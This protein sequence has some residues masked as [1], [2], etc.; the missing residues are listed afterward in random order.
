MIFSICLSIPGQAAVPDSLS[1]QGYLAD[2]SGSPVNGVSTITFSIYN[3]PIEGIPLWTDMQTVPVD[4]GLFSVLLGNPLNPF[5]PGTFDG[6]L[7]IGITVSGDAE[8]VPRRQLTKV[9]YAF[10]AD[11]ASTVQGL[12][13]EALQG[14]TGPPGPPGPPGADGAQGLTGPEGPQGLTGPE[15]PQGLTGPPGADGAQGLPGPE[16][17]QGL[18]GPPGADGAQ[19]LP[20]PEGPQG[21]TGPEGPQGPAG[22][23][24]P[25]GQGIEACPCWMLFQLVNATEVDLNG[26]LVTRGTGTLWRTAAPTPAF[27]V[28]LQP[29]FPEA[30]LGPQGFSDTINFGESLQCVQDIVTAFAPCIFDS[31]LSSAALVKSSAEDFDGDEILDGNDNCATI[32]NADQRDTNNDGIGNACDPDLNNDCIVNLL[33]LAMFRTVFLTDDADADLNGDGAVNLL[34]LAIARTFFPSEPGPSA[35]GCTAAY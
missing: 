24:G 6:P 5:P 23:E 13:P 25:A 14:A 4:Q 11:D 19:G 30:C 16:G 33:D 29:G 8:M 20:G 2:A 26:C 22:P 34:D 31:S 17:P 18:T 9:S 15:G 10:E 3:V 32:G 35:S 1:Y 12:G 21:L 28:L 7:W 27:Q